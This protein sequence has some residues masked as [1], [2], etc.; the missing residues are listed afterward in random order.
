MLGDIF[1]SIAGALFLDTRLDTHQVWKVFEPLLQPMVSPETLPIHPVRG[2]QERCQQEAEGLEYKV[3]R[4]ESVATVEVYVDGVQIGST[5]SAQKKMAQKLGA[6][7]AL[8]K[9]KDKEVIKVKAEAENGDLNA[10][11]SSKNGHTNFTRKTIN[12]LCLKRQWPMPQYKC[13]LESGPAH[14]KKFTFSVRVLTTTDGWTEECVGEPMASV[15]KAKDSAAL[16]LLAAL[17]RSYPL[18]NNIIDC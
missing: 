1:E 4:A 7:N 14:A 3:S 8:V 18:R 10:G 5:Q 16:V 9:L 15:K 2:L 13:V 17:R 6:R 12:D 11:K